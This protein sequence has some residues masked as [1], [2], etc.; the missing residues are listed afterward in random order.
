MPFNIRFLFEFLPGS[1]V[2]DA[3]LVGEIVLGNE[4]DGFQSLIG[5][6]SPLDYKRQ[7]IAGVRRLV[8]E[9]RNSCLITSL[10]NPSY[11]AITWWWLLYPDGD[12]VHVR[13]AL[14]F[15]EDQEGFSTAHPYSAI[16]E[17]MVTND[18]SEAISEWDVPFEDFAMFLNQAG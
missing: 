11:G 4:T 8:E 14:L 15:P 12:I 10:D 18:E 1:T 16:P 7:W 3:A 5:Y 17:R 9:R 2:G 6:W 13:N